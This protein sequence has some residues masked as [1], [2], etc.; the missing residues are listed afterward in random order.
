MRHREAGHLNANEEVLQAVSDLL[1]I[2]FN[3]GRDLVHELEAG[4]DD[5]LP[6][7]DQGGFRIHA[8]MTP[9]RTHTRT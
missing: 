3:R 8:G 9:E 6:A 7:G 4:N 2:P 5:T 1:F